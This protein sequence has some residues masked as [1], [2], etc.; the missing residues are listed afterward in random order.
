MRKGTVLQ[1]FRSL[2]VLRFLTNRLF[3]LKCVFINV[4]SLFIYYFKLSPSFC[5]CLCMYVCVCV[6]VCLCV[7]VCLCVHLCLCVLDRDDPK[8]LLI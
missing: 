1:K 7:S 8:E 5:V 4:I 3:F 2:E 6:C